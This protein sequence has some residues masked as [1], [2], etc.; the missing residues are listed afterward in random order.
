VKSSTIKVYLT[1]LRSYCVDQ[2]Y[3]TAELEV[4]THPQ[5][6][7]TVKGARRLYPAREDTTRE[8]L[9][10]TKDIL[11]RVLSRLDL[12][13]YEGISLHAAFCLA[14]AGFL[15]IGEFTWEPIDWLQA[16]QGAEFANWHVTRNCVHFD[17]PQNAVTGPETATTLPAPEPSRFYLTLPASKT[18]PFRKGVT[19]TIARSPIDGDPACPVTSML[20]YLQKF[21][22]Y[23][24]APLFTLNYMQ[25]GSDDG[26][27]A[28]YL[29]GAAFR[30]AHV[31]GS[32]RRLLFEA[33]IPGN[34]SGHS[35]RRG[36]ATSAR[37]AGIP[38]EDIQLLG[39][40]KSEA[41]KRYIQ[42]H[43]EHLYLAS[44]RLQAQPS[45]GTRI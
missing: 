32:L 1:G 31:V 45:G 17:I 34:Y 22:S 2:G 38:A 18:D 16:D 10:I 43:P 7:R 36:A 23:P 29:P 6:Q 40:W 5:V 15:R 42:V 12:D 20:R 14:F 27:D 44:R 8:R 21:P 39:R 30:R 19:L 13:T 9:P 41:Y 24:D 11:L 4:F 33:G 35:F 25:P 28:H 37:A 3:S 26:L